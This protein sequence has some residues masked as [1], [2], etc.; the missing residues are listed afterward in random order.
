MQIPLTDVRGK[1]WYK[2]QNRF[3]ERYTNYTRPISFLECEL[4]ECLPDLSLMIEWCPVQR[5]K[6][7]IRLGSPSAPF[8]KCCPSCDH[9][10]WHKWN[11]DVRHETNRGSAGAPVR[12]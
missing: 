11:V 4:V 10:L 9:S 7:P 6:C 2:T 1:C 8:P 3:L 5:E 12:C